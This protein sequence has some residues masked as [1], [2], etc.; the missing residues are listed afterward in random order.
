V[1]EKPDGPR[2]RRSRRRSARLKP[3]VMS[4][5]PRQH[6]RTHWCALH[7]PAIRD[8]PPRLC[9]SCRDVA[10]AGQWCAA[11]DESMRNGGVLPCPKCGGGLR[12]QTNGAGEALEIC[13][14]CR[15]VRVISLIPDPQP[16]PRGPVVAR[17]DR[18]IRRVQSTTETGDAAT[19]AASTLRSP[20]LTR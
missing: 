18:R 19:R 13:T 17:L 5:R 11:H 1:I 16:E 15:H 9:R 10:T 3:C 7:G 6:A 4:D 8:F 14:M 20:R 2:R 12:A